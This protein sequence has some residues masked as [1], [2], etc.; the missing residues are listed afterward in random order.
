MWVGGLILNPPFNVGHGHIIGT[1]DNDIPDSA[2]CFQSRAVNAQIEN[3]DG[4]GVST[5]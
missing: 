1:P 3:Y 4:Q 5:A 2:Q